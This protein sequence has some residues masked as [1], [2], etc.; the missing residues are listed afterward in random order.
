[1][2]VCLSSDIIK[3]YIVFNTTYILF[4]NYYFVI[5][6]YAD[7]KVENEEKRFKNITIC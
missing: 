4:K 6:K 2:C 1:M 7:P 5:F 3:Y